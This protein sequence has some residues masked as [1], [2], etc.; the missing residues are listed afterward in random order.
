M[1][2][3]DSNIIIYS[4]SPRFQQVREFLKGKSVF[5]SVISKTEVLG[6]SK[7]S[8]NELNGFVKLFDA[9]PIDHC[10]PST[11]TF[12]PVIKILLKPF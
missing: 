4:L 2:L 6:Y 5:C 8:Q 12:A 11:R 10:F 3:L 1:I 9:L 7:L